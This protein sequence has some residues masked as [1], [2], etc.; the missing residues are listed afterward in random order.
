[1]VRTLQI[2]TWR[3]LG[4]NSMRKGDFIRCLRAA[5]YPTLLLKVPA[6][7]VCLPPLH[8]CPLAQLR[9]PRLPSSF[10]L[11]S[12]PISSVSA[13]RFMFYCVAP[14]ANCKMDKFFAFYNLFFF[15]IVHENI[16]DIINAATP[17]THIHTCTAHTHPHTCWRVVRYICRYAGK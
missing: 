5:C 15:F 12:L 3:E 17:H 1:M 7:N 16:T 2:V 10:S 13:S 6:I 8:Q 14:A 11:P 9:P 4:N